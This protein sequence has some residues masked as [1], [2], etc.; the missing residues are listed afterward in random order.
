M[1]KTYMD[2]IK[3]ISRNII[4]FMLPLFRTI[5]NNRRNDLKYLIELIQANGI[6]EETEK[7]IVIRLII[8]REYAPKTKKIVLDFL[9][10]LS[11]KINQIYDGHKNIIFSI[12]D[13]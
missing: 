4:Y 9:L 2:V 6:I 10:L 8:S 3:I 13:M 5:Y 12:H 7:A 11:C 1:Q